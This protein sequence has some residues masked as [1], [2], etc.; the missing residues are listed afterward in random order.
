MK[1]EWHPKKIHGFK[2]FKYK[3][4]CSNCG[5][6]FYSKNKEIKNGWSIRPKEWSESRWKH[7]SSLECPE[8]E[9]I[10]YNDYLCKDII[11]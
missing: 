11:C 7:W 1:H 8:N 10:T 4:K 9:C 2:T 6:V 3:I 5:A